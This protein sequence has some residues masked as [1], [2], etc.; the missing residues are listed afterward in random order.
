MSM[1]G[2][3]EETVLLR[4]PITHS[5]SHPQGTGPPFLAH[6]KSVSMSGEKGPL[7]STLTSIMLSNPW[8][9]GAA[10]I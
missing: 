4:H 10:R 3:V 2:G 7:V 8:S 1:T 6:L 5:I 9:L